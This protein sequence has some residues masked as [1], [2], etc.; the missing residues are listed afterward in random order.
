MTQKIP[1]L[2]FASLLCRVQ[3]YVAN[4]RSNAPF[5]DFIWRMRDMKFSDFANSAMRIHIRWGLTNFDPRGMS[6]SRMNRFIHHG[7]IFAFMLVLY[8]RGLGRVAVTGLG[9]LVT[10]DE[11]VECSAIFVKICRDAGAK[12]A[13]Q[14]CKRGHTW[15]NHTGC[16]FKVANWGVSLE[17]KGIGQNL[18]DHEQRYDIPSVVIPSIDRN[19]IVQTKNATDTSPITIQI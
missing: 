2:F 4:R 7:G 13:D 17:W 11:A 19:S 18:L 1:R 3:Y 5:L 16:H 14:S 12:M 9:L 10:L 6:L 8:W 15:N